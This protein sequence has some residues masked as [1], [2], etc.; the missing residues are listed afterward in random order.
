MNEKNITICHAVFEDLSS[1]TH[2]TMMAAGIN[3]MKTSETIGNN[4]DINIG[5]QITDTL[6]QSAGN[7]D[8]IIFSAI[9]MFKDK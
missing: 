9:C 1:C 2:N 6:N 3:F 4:I 7:N 8:Y 5:I